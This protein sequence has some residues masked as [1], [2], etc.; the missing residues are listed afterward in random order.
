[1]QTYPLW[2]VHSLRTF[3]SSRPEELDGSSISLSRNLH[4]QLL[5]GCDPSLL[6][7]GGLALVLLH[8]C[9]F[10]HG[11]LESL[12]LDGLVNSLTFLLS[13]L[14]LCGSLVLSR[15]FSSRFQTLGFPTSDTRC[16]ETPIQPYCAFVTSRPRSF[17]T[18]DL[19]H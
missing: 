5:F 17:T 10:D 15:L 19:Q 9:S 16:T 13:E 4:P 14:L 18:R 1:M 7:F 6:P 8:G 11:T 2:C 3:F 12:R